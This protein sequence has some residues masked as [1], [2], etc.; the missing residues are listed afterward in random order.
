MGPGLWG[1]L[2]KLARRPPLVGT[3][4]VLVT[5]LFGGHTGA[6]FEP[7]GPMTVVF[8][9]LARKLATKGRSPAQACRSPFTVVNALR[10]CSRFS[11]ALPPGP[12]LTQM[13]YTVISGS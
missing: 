4:I 5:A 9:A 13:P 10:G 2:R 11:T 6:D 3:I 7:T 1:G 8:T 12:L